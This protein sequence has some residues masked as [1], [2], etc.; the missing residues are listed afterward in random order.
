MHKVFISQQAIS[1][2]ENILTA[3][4]TWQKGVLELEHAL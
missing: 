3:L 1:D 4:I 2:L